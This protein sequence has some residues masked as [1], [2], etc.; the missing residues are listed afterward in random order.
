VQNCREK[1][2][3]GKLSRNTLYHIKSVISG[4]FSHA[5][6]QDYFHGE[7]PARDTKI[8]PK[9]AEPV[10]TYAYSLEE[11]RSILSLL[12]EPAATAFAVAAYMGLRH[13]EIQGLVWENYR[14]GELY[15]SRSIWNGR[16]VAP[17]T[18]KSRAPVPVI[19]LLAQRLELHWLRCGKPSAG[20]MF[21][22]AK[23][24]PLA[25]TSMVNRVILPALNRCEVCHGSETEHKPKDG[26]E[27]KRDASIPEWHGW[28]AGRRGLGSNLHRLG[29]PDKTIQKI[30]RHANV[31]TTVN[32]YIKTADDD[33]R[34]AMAKLETA[35]Q[36]S[37]RTVN[38]TVAVQSPTL[39]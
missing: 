5:K 31:S 26:H 10:D 35:V 32:Y 7:N 13:G 22:N 18:R 27:Y 6:Q 12:P 17:K 19:P 37:Y 2:G 20:S 33:V 8:N 25:L 14:E 9:A 1:I 28:H 29:I 15:V 30:L 38:S 23:G 24:N 3:S 16:E 21:R 4:M 11:I 36:D 34:K 39:Q